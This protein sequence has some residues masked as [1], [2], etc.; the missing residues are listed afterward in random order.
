M[1]DNRDADVALTELIEYAVREGIGPDAQAIAVKV[2]SMVPKAQYRDLFLMLLAYYIR[3]MK[4]RI[5]SVSTPSPAP[6]G[7]GTVKWSTKVAAY[8]AHARFLQLRVN[9]GPRQDKW[10]ADCTYA[11][12]TYAAEQRRKHAADTIAAAE[13]YEA[14]A[15]LVQ[16][17]SVETVGQLSKQDIESFLSHT[18]RAA[19]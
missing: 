1:A 7:G 11:D 14:L 15:V 10:M 19:A 5:S 18:W 3:S 2:E 8:R 6:A 17:R 9:V 4:P 12:L 16:E 13:E